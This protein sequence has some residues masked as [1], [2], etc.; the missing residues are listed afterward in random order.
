[1][2]TPAQRWAQERNWTKAQLISLIGICSNI[3]YKK[4]TLPE[5]SVLLKH[6]MAKVNIVLTNF[7]IEEDTSRRKFLNGGKI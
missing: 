2:A 3:A 4:S 6:A 1:M 5:E 7:K